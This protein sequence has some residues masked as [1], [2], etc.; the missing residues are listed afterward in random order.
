VT[1][2]DGTTAARIAARDAAMPGFVERLG[3]SAD[4]LR[5]ERERRLRRLLTYAKACSPWHRARLAAV[6]PE[7]FSEADLPSL[8]TMTKQDLMG[9]FDAIVTDPALTLAGVNAWIEG[10]P[11]EPLL[12][13]YWAFASGGSSGLRGV[14]VY[15]ADAAVTFNCMVGRWLARVAIPPPG[16]GPAARVWAGRGAHVSWLMLRLFPP[17]GASEAI[18][19]TTP[20]PEIVQRLNAI[21]P[22]SI[23]AYASI[24]GL[25][26]DEARAGRLAIAPTLIQNCGEPLLPEVA[27]SVEA[28]WGVPVYD[29]WGMSE[30]LYA[31]PCAPGAF[32]H[33]PDDICIVEPVDE[34]G[35]PV[36]PGQPAAKLY[37]TNLYN[38]VEPLIRYEVTDQILILDEPCPCGSAHR[39]VGAVHG[40]LDDVFEYPGGIRV[41]PLTVRGPLGRHA[42]VREYQVRQTPTGAHVLL[43]TSGPVDLPALARGLEDGLRSAG[44]ARPQVTLDVVTDLPRQASGKTKRFVPAH[45]HSIVAGGLDETS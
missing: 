31:Q 45:S 27:R 41:H 42:N 18:P 13:R 36:A 32:M 24:L 12:G 15:D 40:R 25:L 19:A 16:A 39:R 29:Y 23:G 8:P 1:H 14:F 26:A 7:R 10:L 3:W 28:A 5:A 33:L 44:L 17:P 4:A 20:L 38:S 6:D 35:R 30:G 9:H 21:R 37:L 34:A 22:W 2:A 43:C 11:D